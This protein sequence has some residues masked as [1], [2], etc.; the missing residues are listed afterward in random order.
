MPTSKKIE[1]KKI[2]WTK[3]KKIAAT[4]LGVAVIAA[5]VFGIIVAA[6]GLGRIKPIKRT[7]MEAKVV[8]ECAGY[9]VRYDELRFIACTCR[10]ELEGKYGNY[11]SLDGEVKASFDAELKERVFDAI[12]NNYA[13]LALAEEYGI[14][15]NSRDV[16][17]NVQAEVELFIEKYYAGEFE[18][19]K[20]ELEKM[21][22][23]DAFFRLIQKIDYIEKLLLEK[24][25]SEKIGVDYS[26]ENIAEF[27]DYVMTGGDYVRTIHAFYPKTSQ[28]IN[29]SNSRQRAEDTAKML[30][31]ISDGEKRY[32]AM[33]SAI[34]EAPFVAGIS[35]TNDG[36]YFTY[37]QMEKEYEV[38]AFELDTYGVSG[39]IE[40]ADGYYVIMRLEPELETVKKKAGELLNQYHYVIIKNAIDAQKEKISFTPNEYFDSLVLGEIK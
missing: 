14:N 33:R 21:G 25:E 8:G 27:T 32:S 16:E 29:T 18:A 6:R 7:D 4:V 22:L 2:E 39:V 37:G 26:V 9:E 38:A 35:M 36:I 31:E 10:S 28:N 1:K 17:K 11:D 23:G 15:A 19:Y 20:D 30:A 3:S 12:E 13:V 40:T 5:I 34:G 24:F